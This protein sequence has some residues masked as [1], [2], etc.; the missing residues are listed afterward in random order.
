MQEDTEHVLCSTSFRSALTL[1]RY[2]AKNDCVQN[3][4]DK[5]TAIYAKKNVANHYF[6]SRR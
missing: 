4:L 6:W 5:L 2:D 3:M 1:I